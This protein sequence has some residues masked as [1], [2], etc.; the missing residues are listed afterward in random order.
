DRVVA[1]LQSA[2]RYPAGTGGQGTAAVS[3][4]VDRSGRVVGRSLVRSSGHSELDREAL[5]MVDRAQPLP[6]F[7]PAMTQARIAL[8]VPVRFSVR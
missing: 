4:T 5:A 8:T 3:F 2:K 7:P 6:P 1:R